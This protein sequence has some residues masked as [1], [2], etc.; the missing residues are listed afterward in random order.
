MKKLVLVA[1]VAC[2]LTLQSCTT[3]LID[4]TVISSK[5]VNLRSDETGKRVKGKSGGFLGLGV[6]IKSAVDDAIQKGPAGS[7]ALIDGV[8]SQFNYPFYAG[9][10]VEGTPINTKKM[11]ASLSTE[12][13]RLFAAEHNL[14]EL[15]Q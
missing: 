12:E 3:R 10:T 1:T 15:G 14:V 8:I 7:D 4:F 9:F 5:T 6:N 11:K 13:Y 2:A